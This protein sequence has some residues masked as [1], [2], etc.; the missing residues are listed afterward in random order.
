M[1][2]LCNLI[3][4]TGTIQI[5]SNPLPQG[6]ILTVSYL[7]FCVFPWMYCSGSAVWQARI[8]VRI[9]LC[10]RHPL[11]K[12]LLTMLLVCQLI[13]TRMGQLPALPWTLSLDA[14]AGGLLLFASNIT[15][16]PHTGSA[17]PLLS[18]MPLVLS[19]LSPPVEHW[20]VVNLQFTCPQSVIWV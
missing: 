14:A 13:R 16:L 5:A 4:N 12:D 1:L 6:D 11:L 19:R 7:S 2:C 8:W 3:F 9:T 15:L 18:E 10:D 20:W 17:S